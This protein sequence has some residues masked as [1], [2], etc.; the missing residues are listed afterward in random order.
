MEIQPRRP[1]TLYALDRV[2]APLALSEDQHTLLRELALHYGRRL[3]VVLDR[4][5]ELEYELEW[6]RC[7]RQQNELQLWRCK[8]RAGQAQKELLQIQTEF[9]WEIQKTLSREQRRALDRILA[10]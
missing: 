3:V 2:D 5:Q 9:Q 6:L 1:F 7:T 10:A 4:L 8:K